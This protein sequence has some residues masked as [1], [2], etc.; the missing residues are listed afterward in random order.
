MRFFEENPVLQCP[1]CGAPLHADAHSLF[2]DGVRRHNFD[3]A[4]SGYVN[5][6]THLPTSGDDREMAAARQAFLR[7]EY[8][9][10]FAEAVADA[11]ASGRLLAD[12]GCGEGYYTELAAK[13]FDAAIGADL[14]KY[15]LDL[16]AKSAKRV[17]LSDKLLYAAAGVYA[18]PLANE[19][20]DCVIN[21]FAPCAEE[22]YTRVLRPGGK[23]IVAAA[24]KD[25]LRDLKAVLYDTVIPN[26]ERRDLPTNLRKTE[27]R[28]VTYTI[29][30]PHEDIHPLF[31]MTPYYYRTKREAAERLLDTDRLTTLL[32]FEI[33]IYTKETE[34]CSV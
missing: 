3:F 5:F 31:T 15:A 7:K 1:L 17:G 24:G 30:V 8:Y 11:A 28:R 2:C 10:P 33:R 20:C 13:N 34:S 27:V 22:E 26:E 18:L 16:A 6:N 21:V 4:K 12:A 29:T 23:L 14:S 25:H 9:A 19:S 32:D